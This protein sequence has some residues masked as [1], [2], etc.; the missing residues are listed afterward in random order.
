MTVNANDARGELCEGSYTSLFIETNGQLFTP[1]LSVGLLP[2][3]LRAELIESRRVLE[4]TLRIDDMLAADKLYVGNSLRGLI[5]AKLLT[6]K[7]Q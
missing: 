2:G 4:K 3:I 1:P 6:S 7:P 5:P